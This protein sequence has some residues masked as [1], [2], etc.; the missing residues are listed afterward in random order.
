MFSWETKQPEPNVLFLPMQGKIL[1]HMFS[2]QHIFH[3]YQ[4]EIVIISHHN[5]TYVHIHYYSIPSK[6][7]D[8]M[9]THSAVY[10]I[11]YDG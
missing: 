8:Y 11:P 6:T 4:Y 9:Q 2:N 3:P 5:Y 10:F 7:L 1:Y